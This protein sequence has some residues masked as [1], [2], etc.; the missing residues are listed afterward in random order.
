MS[1]FSEAITEVI[2]VI[3]NAF[4]G[5][6]RPVVAYEN[7]EADRESDYEERYASEEESEETRWL[8]RDCHEDLNPEDL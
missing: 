4:H 1:T 2:E 5:E 3:S 7:A 6:S 8:V